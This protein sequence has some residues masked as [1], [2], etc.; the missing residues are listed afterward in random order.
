MLYKIGIRSNH[1]ILP[2][3]FR[4]CES[5]TSLICN[6][7]R[8]LIQCYWIIHRVLK[9]NVEVFIPRNWNCSKYPKLRSTLISTRLLMENTKQNITKN[10]HMY[11]HK[12]HVTR[13]MAK[14]ISCKYNYKMSYPTIQDKYKHEMYCQ[15]IQQCKSFA[16]LISNTRRLLIQLWCIYRVKLV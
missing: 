6:T 5:F 13:K 12:I 2:F 11:K 4:F 10:C 8:L 1:Q 15:K 14:Y 16:S 3:A 9:V 7:P